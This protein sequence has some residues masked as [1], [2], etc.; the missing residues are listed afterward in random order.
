MATDNKQENSTE[1][2]SIKEEMMSLTASQIMS[3]KYSG[4]G[5]AIFLFLL[6]TLSILSYNYMMSSKIVH[7]TKS[8][9]LVARQEV[10]VQTLAKE[11]M[12]IELLNKQNGVKKG[13]PISDDIILATKQLEKSVKTF[14]ETLNAFADGGEVVNNAGETI[15]LKK[16]SNKLGKTSIENAQVLWQPYKRLIESFVISVKEKNIDDESIHFASNYARIF[17]AKLFREMKDLEQVIVSQAT[18]KNNAVKR[19]QVIGFILVT[20]LFIYSI[21]GALRHL[22][23]RDSQLVQARRQTTEI[24]ATVKEGLF[25]IDKQLVISEEYSKILEEILNQ[26]EIAGKT[27]TDILSSIISEKDLETTKIFIDQLYSDWVVEDL[28]NDLNPLHQIQ[29]Q[30]PTENDT[31]VERYLDFKFS[32]VY[33]AEKIIHILV[34]VYDVTESVLLERSLEREKEQSDRQLEML[35]CIIDSDHSLLHHFIQS[36]F[37]RIDR[38]NNIL[39]ERGNQLT[40]LHGKINE[41]YREIHSLKGEAS[42]LKLESFVD[43]SEKIESKIKEL[44]DN[45]NLVGNDF[46]SLTIHL[47]ELL[48]LTVFIDNLTSRV[49]NNSSRVDAN[50]A[51]FSPIV[52]NAVNNANN[53]PKINMEEYYTQ[54]AQEIA[55]RNGKE[56]SFQCIGM[57]NIPLT[58]EQNGLIKD[59]SIQLL[60]NAIV[61]GIELPEEREQYNK[62]REGKLTLRLENN[63]GILVLSMTDDGQGINYEKIRQTALDS[64]KYNPEIVESWTEKDLLQLLFITGFSTAE[65][66]DEDAGRGIGMDIIRNLV[67]QLGGRLKIGSEQNV[68]SRFTITFPPQQQIKG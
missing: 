43:L 30:I 23:Q 24:L 9:E 19:T 17:N 20:L 53:P 63:N 7:L 36:T 2:Q 49:R 66:Q 12:D 32:R 42:S 26:K 34:H 13:E 67:K 46:L 52:E 38:I 57:D 28:I 5:I 56:I 18:D 55:E 6:I 62:S 50:M 54:F 35:S 48:K 22:I 14:D 10:L 40:E 37:N 1:K 45:P 25:L 11:V 47:D 39:R 58:L 4:I 27:L 51:S 8:A 68:Y 60:R 3:S 16:M 41:I 15:K 61:H 65:T 59:I 33:E 64:G 44:I 29:V 21:F 31:F